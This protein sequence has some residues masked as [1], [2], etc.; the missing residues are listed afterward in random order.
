M[1]TYGIAALFTN[2]VKEALFDRIVFL[3]GQFGSLHDE[4]G[5]GLIVSIVRLVRLGYGR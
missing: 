2:T 1:G 3:L 4:C 5:E